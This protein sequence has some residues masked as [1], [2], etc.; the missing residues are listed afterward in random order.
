MRVDRID[1][2]DDGK[3]VRV[4]DYKTARKGLGPRKAHV[5][6]WPQ[7]LRPEPL[8]PLLILR[9]RP[10]GWADLQLPLYVRTVQQA[11]NQESPP[12]AWYVLLP[13]AVSETGFEEFEGLEDMLGNAMQWAEEAARRIVQGVF[14]PPAPEVQYDLFASIAPEGLQPALGAPWADF[15]AGAL[16]NGGRVR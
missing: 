1:R 6:T 4:I 11:M 15:L 14:W 8:G 5:R 12:Q 16:A 10:Y 13:D 7:E 9:N 2:H 3:R